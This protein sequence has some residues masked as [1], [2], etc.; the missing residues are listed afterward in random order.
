MDS[1]VLRLNDLRTSEGMQANMLQERTFAN[2]FH[3]FRRKTG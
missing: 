3:A 2:F 1:I